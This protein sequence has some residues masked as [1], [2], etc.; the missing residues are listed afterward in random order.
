MSKNL[1]SLNLSAEQLTAVDTALGELER[2]LSVLVSL[3]VADKRRVTPM[4]EKSEAFCRQTL[5]LLAENPQL[6]P[7][8]LDVADALSDLKSLDVLRPRVVRLTR[9][10]SR[11]QDTE[12]A[13]GCDA[14]SVA[15]RGYSLLKGVSDREG[16]KEL[17]RGLGVRFAKTRR[18]KPTE[19]QAA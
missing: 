14:M 1:V 3:S 8:N 9:L 11:A 17:R 6:V 2:Q 13:L 5:Q 18:R 10:L 19:Q 7:P 16:L 4:G 15:M 12:F